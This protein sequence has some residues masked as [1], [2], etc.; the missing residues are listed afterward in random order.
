MKNIELISILVPT[1]NRPKDMRGLVESCV[2]TCDYVDDLEF[3]FYI[4]DDDNESLVEAENLRDLVDLKV[5]VGE[6]IVLSEMWNVCCDNAKGDIFMHCG[7]DLRFRTQSWDTK[8]REK[9]DSFSDK[10][11][12]VFGHDSIFKP[13]AFGTHGFLHRTWVEVVGYFVPPYFSS[14]YNDTW[15]NDVSKMIDRHCY[16]DIYTEH[17]HFSNGK[18]EKDQTHLDR[19][20][21][22]ERDKVRSLYDSLNDKRVED[23]QKLNG[24]IL[25]NM[26]LK[27][28]IPNWIS[29]YSRNIDSLVVGISGGVDSAVTSTLCAKTGK[30]TILVS[31]PIH[32]NSSQL[33]RAQNHIDWLKSKYDNVTSVH[34]DLSS[35]FDVFSES[36]VDA[37]DLSL[38]NSRS[39]LRMTALYQ[40]SS[41]NNGIVVGTG[42]KVEDFGVGFF[43]KY[44]DGGVDISP[45]AD[46]TKSEVWDLASDLE[47]HKDIIEAPPTDGLWSDDRTDEDQIGATYR[48]LEWAMSF[49]GNPRALEGRE[50]EV[51]YIYKKLNCANQHK[52]NP[53]PIFKK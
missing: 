51:Y 24:F 28:A 9:F 33:E 12:F 5:I 47:I 19:L 15:L 1:R 37:S 50:K 38:A 2:S 36:F 45:I 40:I 8:V 39:R 22:H 10:I 29:R 31:L 20:A 30:K 43:T 34:L 53:I 23:A 3:V 14:D 52:M 11:A 17:L 26:E 44:G 48:E 4:D 46:L 41:M 16:V 13:G 25:G 7:D 35:L 18:H 21:R 49:V 32:Q 6:R 42:N 27:N